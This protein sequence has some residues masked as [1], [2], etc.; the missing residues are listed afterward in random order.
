MTLTT[1]AISSLH[2]PQSKVI[3]SNLKEA[4]GLQEKKKK[5]KKKGGESK[6][7][8]GDLLEIETKISDQ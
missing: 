3:Q 5:Q 4:K 2:I 8:K 6:R 1:T 7:F